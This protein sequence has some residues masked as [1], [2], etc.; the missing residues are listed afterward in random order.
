MNYN[1]KL[2]IDHKKN[3]LKKLISKSRLVVF[4]YDSTG[5]LELLT[6]NIPILAFWQNEYDYLIEEAKPFYTEL[7]KAGVFH[8]SP[9]TAAVKVNQIWNNVDNWWSSTLVQEARLNFCSN[10]S[11]FCTKPVTTLKKL[12][13]E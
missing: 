13:I 1:S 12:L 9:I 3:N 10:Y 8:F 5:I 4:A 2:I 6:L 11:K 7:V